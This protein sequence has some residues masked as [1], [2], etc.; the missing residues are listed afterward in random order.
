MAK[1]FNKRLAAND[2]IH[3]DMLM[4][5]EKSLECNSGTTRKCHNEAEEDDIE[6]N[7]DVHGKYCMPNCIAV[8]K[9]LKEEDFLSRQQ[10]S[11]ALELIKDPQNRIIVMCL[12]D[13]MYDLAYWIFYKYE[14][15]EK[16]S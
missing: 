15:N 7:S 10:F 5:S 2:T 16:L 12:Q 1:F 4:A 8:L 6:G 14:L 11:F 13:S 9:S 3:D